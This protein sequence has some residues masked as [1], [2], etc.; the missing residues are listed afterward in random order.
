MAKELLI[1]PAV[2][3]ATT[4]V[5]LGSI[6]VNAYQPDLEQERTLYGAE[7]LDRVG[8]DMMLVREFELML[9]AIKRE[10]SYLGGPTSTPAPPISPSARRPLPS[11]RR[12]LWAWRTRSSAAIEAMGR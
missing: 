6:P 11:G 4:E 8:R 1:D 5:E 9:N 2:V 12:S 7:A 10:G 3:R